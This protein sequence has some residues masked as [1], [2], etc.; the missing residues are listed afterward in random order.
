MNLHILAGELNPIELIRIDRVS[1]YLQDVRT[2]E[3]SSQS[4]GC[5][6]CGNLEKE[7]QKLENKM[8]HLQQQLIKEKAGPCQCK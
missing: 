2:R 1:F 3:M 6:R 7:V 5:L 4:V 8:C